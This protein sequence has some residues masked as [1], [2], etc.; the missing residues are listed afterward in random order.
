SGSGGDEYEPI[1][2]TGGERSRRIVPWIVAGA[3]AVIA[4][5]AAVLIVFAVRGG[6]EAP[7]PTAA[8]QP[9]TEQPATEEPPTPNEEESPEST[10]ST[11][12]PPPS[13]EPPAVE[14]GNTGTMDIPAWGVT[15][16]ISAKFG[17]P[18]YTIDANNNLL[19]ADG[20][21]LPQFPDSCQE[22][23]TGF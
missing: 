1:A 18:R 14:V 3:G 5:I 15:S 17:W 20:T 16:Q 7:A 2:V 21:L 9:T 22:M 19:L 13:D 4:L 23:R 8:P 11:P 12:T 6:D 10:P